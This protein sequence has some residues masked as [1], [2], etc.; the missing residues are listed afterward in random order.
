MLAGFDH[1]DRV[2]MRQPIDHR[3]DLPRHLSERFGVGHCAL[4]FLTA[5]CQQ[6]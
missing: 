2:V 5:N 6:P 1:L 4:P 3:V